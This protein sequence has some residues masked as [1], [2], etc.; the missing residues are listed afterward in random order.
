[1]NRTAVARELLKLAKTLV[2]GPYSKGPYTTPEGRR[3][4]NLRRL[5]E[6]AN[7]AQVTLDFKYDMGMPGAIRAADAALKRAISELEDYRNGN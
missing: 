6:A 7:E 2:G 1:M 5:E 3:D 4:R